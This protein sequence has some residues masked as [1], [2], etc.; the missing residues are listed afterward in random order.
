MIPS[1]TKT[2]TNANTRGQRSAASLSLLRLPNGATT[3]TPA[4]WTTRGSVEQGSAWRKLSSIIDNALAIIDDD[5]FGADN[6][7]D[8]DLGLS[9]K[10]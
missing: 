2:T 9:R 10:E 4:L 3:E 6:N 5:E 8:F 1:T 7:E